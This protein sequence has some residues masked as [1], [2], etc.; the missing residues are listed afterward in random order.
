MAEGEI[1]PPAQIVSEPVEKPPLKA[2]IAAIEDDS[3]LRK[4]DISTVVQETMSKHKKLGEFVSDVMKKALTPEEA[5]LI[6]ETTYVVY[7]ITKDLPPDKEQVEVIKETGNRL[8]VSAAIASVEEHI[9]QRREDK[10]SIYH[11][12]QEDMAEHPDLASYVAEKM[13]E[14]VTLEEANLIGE[15]ALTVYDV[16]RLSPQTD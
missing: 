14:S 16:L 13:R 12:L 9:D 8:P 10:N 1:P 5:R 3:P 11:S 7:N 4:N 6:G 15:T 2:L